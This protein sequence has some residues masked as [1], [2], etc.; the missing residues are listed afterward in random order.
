MR[1]FQAEWQ[2]EYRNRSEKY[3]TVSRRRRS[4]LLFHEKLPCKLQSWRW[5]NAHSA[6]SSLVCKICLVTVTL[7]KLRLRTTV[8]KII[9][10]QNYVQCRTWSL[11]MR[12]QENIFCP[13]LTD[14]CQHLILTSIISQPPIQCG[15]HIQLP[16]APFGI[17]VHYREPL[18]GSSQVLWNWVKNCVLFTYCKQ[19]KAIFSPHFH[20]TW[21]GPFSASL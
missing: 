6:R 8:A 7:S 15:R 4:V 20:T 3:L 11:M 13:L 14:L 5:G 2:R 21:K 19:E 16:H 12:G 17:V 10:W 18:K 1:R 9:R